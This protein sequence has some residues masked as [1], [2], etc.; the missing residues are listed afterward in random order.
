MLTF[1]DPNQNPIYTDPLNSVWEFNG[2]GW[3]RQC[4]C[5]DGGDGGNGGNP[6]PIE[7]DNRYNNTRCVINGEFGEVGGE[8]I[9]ATGKSII[10]PTAGAKNIEEAKY[11]NGG[12]SLLKADYAR[13]AVPVEA[14]FWRRP[15]TLEG[16]FQFKS[17]A[18][19]TSNCYNLFGNWDT[20]NING[21]QQKIFML[22][23]NSN[24][25]FE[26]LISY[27]GTTDDV[28]VKIDTGAA[29]WDEPD[30]WYHVAASH[31]MNAKFVNVYLDGERLTSQS[32]AQAPQRE[33]TQ[34]VHLANREGRGGN[35]G[36]FFMDDFRLTYDHCR[37]S[38]DTFDPPGQVQYQQTYQSAMAE[39]EE[40]RRLNPEP[41][42][43]DAK[44]FEDF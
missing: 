6:D 11:G 43:V 23:A 5:P 29:L 22:R 13:I 10:V 4:D 19:T 33:A 21:A 32:I 40:Y 8:P 17:Q 3:V 34:Q 36:D 25:Q 38:T 24:K 20:S 28:N 27:T 16:W 26:L 9:D 37:Y 39:L 2:T 41:E 30:R 35:Q 15:W 31:Q 1:P 12:V 14:N 18:G 44:D 42:F 7:P